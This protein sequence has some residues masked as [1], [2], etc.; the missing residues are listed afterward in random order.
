MANCRVSACLLSLS[1]YL[2]LIATPYS[3]PRLPTFVLAQLSFPL[4][5]SIRNESSLSIGSSQITGWRAVPTK[6]SRKFRAEAYTNAARGYTV[7]AT[8]SAFEIILVNTHARRLIA[9]GFSALHSR[10]KETAIRSAKRRAIVIY[11]IQNAT[12]IIDN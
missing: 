5:P 11:L 10:T 7:P 12:L 6:L 8:R 4:R 2:S 3:S 1:L 9:L